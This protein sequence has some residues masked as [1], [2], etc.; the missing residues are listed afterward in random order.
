MFYVR[1]EEHHENTTGESL[2]NPYFI[3]PKKKKKTCLFA[4]LMVKQRMIN[5]RNVCFFL[6]SVVHI[7]YIFVRFVYSIHH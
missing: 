3:L 1:L 2:A 6:I 5:K 4:K 7:V